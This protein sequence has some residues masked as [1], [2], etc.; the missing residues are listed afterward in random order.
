MPHGASMR[1]FS[2]LV[3]LTLI[4][5]P[6]A[7][8]QGTGQFFDSNGVQIHYIDKGAGEP[9]VLMH[10]LNGDYQRSWFEP[11]IAHALVDAGYRVLALDGRAHGWSPTC[12]FR[13]AR[14]RPGSLTD[15]CRQFPRT[16]TRRGF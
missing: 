1:R 9:V 10:G 15:G 16:K 12:S 7:L 3:A 13:S 14:P 5:A 8:A 11:G 4:V 2:R 6:G